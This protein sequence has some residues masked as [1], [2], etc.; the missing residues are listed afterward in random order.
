MKFNFTFSVI[1]RCQIFDDN[2][3]IGEEDIELMFNEVLAASFLFK[4]GPDAFKIGDYKLQMKYNSNHNITDMVLKDQ[5]GKIYICTNFKQVLA[6]VHDGYLRIKTFDKIVD[7]M[8][9]D[10]K[11]GIDLQNPIEDEFE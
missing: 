5:E 8:E 10:F 9:F 4:F 2:E 6:D 7:I 3:N 11:A 1:A